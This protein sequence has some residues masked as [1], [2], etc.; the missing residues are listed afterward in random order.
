MKTIDQYNQETLNKAILKGYDIRYIE[1]KTAKNRKYWYSV[2][3]L[4]NGRLISGYG[5]GE[6]TDAIKLAKE[7]IDTKR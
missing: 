3:I 4:D 6:L 1:H 7:Y 5:A 2:E